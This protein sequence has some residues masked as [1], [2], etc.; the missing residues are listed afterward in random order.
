MCFNN[1]GENPR[2]QLLLNYRPHSMVI[3][4]F[5]NI[6]GCFDIVG[7]ANTNVEI[8]IKSRSNNRD[9]HY[10]FSPFWL[11]T[12]DTL[13]M[14][15]NRADHHRILHRV[16]QAIHNHIVVTSGRILPQNPNQCPVW[17]CVRIKFRFP[18]VPCLQKLQTVV[19]IYSAK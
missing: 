4:G 11:V 2:L 12:V 18:P 8:R 5:L 13:I 9:I 1:L 16:L 17:T 3:T 19:L 6:H 10:L 15:T 7:G 14:F